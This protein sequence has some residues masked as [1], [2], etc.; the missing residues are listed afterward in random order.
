MKLG[1]VA[2]L[3]QELTPTLG[4]I[5]STPRPIDGLRFHDSPHL[6]FVAAGVGARPAAAAALLMAD[7]FKPDALLSVGFCGALV[8][9]LVS[10]DVVLGGTTNHPASASLL[11]LARPCLVKPHLGNVLTVPKVIVDAAE[12]RELA[13]NSGALVIDMEA[14][15][16]AVAAKAR[17]LGFLS[18][19]VVID[20]PAAPLASTYAGCWTVFK[21]LV[22]HPG[23]I[24]AM[25]YDAKRVKLAAERLKDFFV[26]VEKA[27][28]GR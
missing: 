25:V 16:V 15:A 11:D 7:T 19:K 12:K 14:E 18:V 1:V 6:S 21:D 9:D 5:P 23:S 13:K 26:G 24:M 27:V 28:R 2:A 8:D 17:G 3:R 10:S 4:A 22:L 20:T